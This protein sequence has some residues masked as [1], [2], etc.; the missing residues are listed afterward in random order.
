MYPKLFSWFVFISVFVNSNSVFALSES[1][2]IESMQNEMESIKKQFQYMMNEINHLKKENA[3][4]KMAIDKT[5]SIQ[6]KMQQGLSTDIASDDALPEGFT[7]HT[8]NPF[9]LRVS[10]SATG[11]LQ[12]SAGNN[13]QDTTN[14]EGSFDL[15]FEGDVCE[16]GMFLIDIEA[17]G[18][19]GPDSVL[20]TYSGV[21]D[22]SGSTDRHVDVLE[23]WYEQSL[24]DDKFVFTVGLIDLTN[25]F[26]TN[27]VA[28][29]ETT[30][31]LA[32][33]FVNSN[34]LDSPDNGPGIRATYS[35]AD[36]LDLHLGLQSG[37]EDGDFVF[38][39]VFFISGLD[40]HTE[41]FNRAG[42]YRVY[43]SVNGNRH[44]AHNPDENDESVGFG[45][46]FDQAIT[47]KI[48]AFARLGF[49]DDQVAESETE[50]AWSTGF[51]IAEP[52]VSRPD[53]KI[54]VA[55]GQTQPNR[56]VIPNFKRTTFDYDSTGNEQNDYMAS[57][58]TISEIYYSYQ[59]SEKFTVTPLMQLVFQPSGDTHEDAILIG[60]LRGQFDF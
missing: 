37:D 22:D 45:L 52:F 31:F 1:G 24:L 13:P 51:Q 55:I 56:E 9:G 23:A 32:S 7:Q 21:N 35:F 25:Y 59:I 58:E 18:N 26:D 38:N 10:A 27:E 16:G 57:I 2:K 33:A 43:L 3:A 36:W 34:V 17:V 49:R 5:N 42:N 6:M 60:G 15:I 4:L 48:T 46:S 50:W 53:D 8:V 20:G 54:G 41:F 47:D 12:C 14:A 39:R 40:F 11:V 19:N 30:Q 44:D 28:N 29:D